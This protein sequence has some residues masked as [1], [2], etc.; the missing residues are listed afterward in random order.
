M[1][2]PDVPHEASTPAEAEEDRAG[3]SAADE[4]EPEP[5]ARPDS[6]AQPERQPPPATPS[7]PPEDRF[8]GVPKELLPQVTSLG[9]R[10]RAEHLHPIILSIWPR[11]GVDDGQAARAL[12]LQA[13]AG[14]GAAPS[15]AAGGRGIP[16]TPIPGQGPE[17]EPGIPDQSGQVAALQVVTC[18]G[19]SEVSRQPHRLGIP[20]PAWSATDGGTPSAG[21][22]PLF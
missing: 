20:G 13:S 2:P 4:L 1:T 5:E 11:P 10:T 17:P 6:P 15:R 16:D 7:A 14:L 3:T 22:G 9:E 8:E 21:S 12:V 18:P 19:G